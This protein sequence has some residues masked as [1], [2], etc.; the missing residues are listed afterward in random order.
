MGPLDQDCKEIARE[1]CQGTNEDLKAEDTYVEGDDAS[2]VV[3]VENEALK[4]KLLLLHALAQDD[5]IDEFVSQFVPADISKDDMEFYAD[6]LKSKSAVGRK[7]ESQWDILK[8]EIKVLANG[9]LTH[10]DGDVES[11]S[12][13]CMTFQHPIEVLCDREVTFRFQNGDWRADA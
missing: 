3:T 4:A 8:A 11:S 7:G 13:I 5:K 9:P 10:V 12:C 1:S 6:R 2:V